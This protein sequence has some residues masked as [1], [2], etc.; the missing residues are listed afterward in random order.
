MRSNM[1]YEDIIHTDG[2]L[3][4]NIGSESEIITRCT[5]SNSPK[6]WI[7]VESH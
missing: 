1:V 7:E 4:N 3:I 2:G 6:G 5:N